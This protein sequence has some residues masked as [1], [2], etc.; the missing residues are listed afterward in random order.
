MNPLLTPLAWLG[1]RSAEEMKDCDSA[2]LDTS[3]TL[4]VFALISAAMIMGGQ[5]LFWGSIPSTAPNALA[6]AAVLTCVYTLFYRLLMRASEVMH[7]LAKPVVCVLGAVVMG[8]N[9]L[10]AG[11]ELVMLP[12]APQVQEM[13][14]LTSAQNVT[15]LRDAV[16][17][18]LS[19]GQLRAD[20]Q[21][22]Q[23]QVTAARQ[24][25]ARVPDEVKT[26]QTQTE[27]CDTTARAMK[28]RL[29]SADDDSY[30]S[31]LAALRQHRAGCNASRSQA[32]QLLLA[33]RNAA[34]A[35]LAALQAR[36]ATQAQ[37]LSNASGQQAT[38]LAQAAPALHNSATTGFARHKA[39]WAA[40]AAGKVPWWAAY[41]LML[42]ALALEGAA[43]MLKFLLP[44]DAATYR[45]AE[46][47]QLV[48]MQG[49]ANL[50]YARA[51][52]AQVR[53]AM[54]AMAKTEGQQTVKDLLG[55]VV[56]NSFNTRTAANAFAS[57]HQ[58]VRKAQ[59]R[60][61]Q[62]AFDALPHLAATAAGHEGFASMGA[63]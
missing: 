23:A 31:A 9:A 46:D 54:Q 36:A 43:F 28:A 56:A 39:L 25:L 16:G 44:K 37:S 6:I 11:H 13:A 60:T 53:P 12:F 26:L 35:D 33:H 52:R 21:S 3:I 59:Q 63:R 4:G 48:C 57:A 27:Q 49:D 30:A 14:A 38:A 41:G 20:A 29:S 19:L 17:T 58:S 5:T 22:L 40:V 1:G 18:S 7:W 2:A 55:K 24:E 51:M 34:G 61:G 10:L 32:S 62:A 42:V 50:A 8:V 47:T 15:T 45:R